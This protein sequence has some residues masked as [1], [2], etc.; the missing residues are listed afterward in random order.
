MFTKEQI[1]E[2]RD[3]LAIFSVKDS[4]FNT[5]T[6][7]LTGEE[8]VA[9]VQNSLNVKT[10]VVAFQDLVQ[11]KLPKV[12]IGSS[13]TNKDLID[14]YR[15]D[16]MILL[17]YWKTE[18]PLN[19]LMGT[20]NFPMVSS[21]DAGALNSSDYNKFIGYNSTLTSHTTL[22]NNHS[23]TLASHTNTLNNHETNITTNT[24]NISRLVS[25]CDTINGTAVAALTLGK[26][27]EAQIIPPIEAT[28]NE[29]K[30][31]AT[32]NRELINTI[33]SNISKLYELNVVYPSSLQNLTT[34]STEDDIKKA[35]IPVVGGT[36]GVVNTPHVGYLIQTSE[37]S[38][39]RPDCLIICVE[40]GSVTTSKGVTVTTHKILYLKNNSDYYRLEVSLDNGNYFV[41]EVTY[42]GKLTDWKQRFAYIDA[43][44]EKIEDRYIDVLGQ[45]NTANTNIATNTANIAS[46]TSNITTIKSDISDINAMYLSLSEKITKNTNDIEINASNIK[47][48][49]E[50]IDY[51]K[52]TI[53]EITHDINDIGDKITANTTAITE[54]QDKLP[55]MWA[56]ILATKDTAVMA[57]GVRVEIPAYT[58]T[59]IKDFKTFA[60]A[61]NTPN[62]KCITRFDIHYNG[63]A[64]VKSVQFIKYYQPTDETV[65]N[66]YGM[67]SLTNLDVS[68]WDTSGVTTGA[69]YMF[70]LLKNVTALDVRGF[71]T[72]NMTSMQ[73][74][75]LNC[76]NLASVDVSG[77]NTSKV[78]NMRLVFSSCLLLETIDVSGFDTQNVT[79]IESMFRWGAVQSL[80]LH[81]WDLSSCTNISGFVYACSSLTDIT[82]GEG[83]GKAK[84]SGLT[85]DL[86]TCG[87][88]NSYVLTDNTYNSM[89]TMYDRA[90]NG[91]PTMTIKFN[92]KHNLP[93]GFVAAMTAR[94]Y[95][96]TQ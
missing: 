71:D 95:T 48:N 8:Y 36:A 11:A 9:L 10:S 1:I 42:F 23:A 82:F 20:Y 26:N 2:I 94:G 86:S 64:K 40:L 32:A 50:A 73:G 13:D 18:Y 60:L 63:I 96:I 65:S 68:G 30:A 45:I 3:K 15:N 79:T 62:P 76:R 90:T 25:R 91:L 52:S 37:G 41:N 7:P 77:F 31:S 81:N 55:T 17:R 75:F 24:N 33:N 46:N 84:A 49:T 67:V 44:L 56:N 14:F 39:S 6:L 70:Y 58:N 4:Q 28:A 92:A 87:S 29:A 74:M 72:S 5:A 38:Y 21:T 66:D 22:I 89:L 19:E 80:D 51:N 35:F 85:L 61:D 83:F 12:V 27:L 53:K 16:S 57:D 47:T 69:S 93:D 88:N 78:T 54:L 43:Q 59:V 34:E